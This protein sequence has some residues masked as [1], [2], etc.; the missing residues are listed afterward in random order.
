MVHSSS[1]RFSIRLNGPSMVNMKISP[2][3][4]VIGARPPLTEVGKSL[5]TLASRSL[6]CWRAQ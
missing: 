6:T 3:G 5:S 1:V 4:V 2:S